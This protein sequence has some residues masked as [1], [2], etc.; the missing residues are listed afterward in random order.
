MKHCCNDGGGG[1]GSNTTGE[2]ESCGREEEK[3]AGREEP[4]ELGTVS[5]GMNGTIV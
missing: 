3:E 5:M 1:K 4:G 2:S